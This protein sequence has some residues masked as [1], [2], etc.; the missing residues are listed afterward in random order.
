MPLINRIH[1]DP[2]PTTSS[3]L[4][5]REGTAEQ[6]RVETLS[7]LICNEPPPVSTP[8]HELKSNKSQARIGG[9]NTIDGGSGGSDGGR[10]KEAETNNI[11]SAFGIVAALSAA[12]AFVTGL[13]KPDLLGE[14]IT[15][16]IVKPILIFLA[17]LTGTMFCAGKLKEDSEGSIGASPTGF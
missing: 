3:N 1:N 4:R 9:N 8:S 7:T 13:I 5:L 12:G 17:I 6:P 10:G 14:K 2:R 11:L 16:I 15:P